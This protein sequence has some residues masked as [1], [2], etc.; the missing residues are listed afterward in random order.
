MTKQ[1]KIF[2]TRLQSDL[3]FFQWFTRHDKASVNGLFLYNED[4]NSSF[5]FPVFLKTAIRPNI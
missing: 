3:N 5:A 1:T 2:R 4:K